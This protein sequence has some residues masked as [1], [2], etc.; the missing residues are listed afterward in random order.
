MVNCK[1]CLNKPTCLFASLLPECPAFSR[2]TCGQCRHYV[3]F[4]D[5]GKGTCDV[6]GERVTIYVSD[7]SCEHFKE[8]WR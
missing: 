2:R 6:E 3:S 5:F 8:V 7:P 4:E 1:F